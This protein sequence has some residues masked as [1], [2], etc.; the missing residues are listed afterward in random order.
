MRRALI[1][2]F[3]CLVGFKFY[4]AMSEGQ[5][6]LLEKVP[7][8]L[9]YAALFGSPQLLWLAKCSKPLSGSQVRV[10]AQVAI[11]FTLLSM[12]FGSFPGTH[13]PSWAGGS[14]HFEVPGAWVGEW[15]VALVALIPFRAAR[16]SGE[17]GA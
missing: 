12:Y 5:S 6:L 3:V 2:I 8:A 1:G 17:H 11:V 4:A 7:I 10:A 16:N 9:M 15:V 14:A 13:P